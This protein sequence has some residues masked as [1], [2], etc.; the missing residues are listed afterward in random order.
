MYIMRRAIKLEPRP[1]KCYV[2]VY[3]QKSF[4]YLSI[5]LLRTKY[6]S[7]SGFFFE[8]DVMYKE[9]TGIPIDLEEIQESNKEGQV[10]ETNINL[11]SKPT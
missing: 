6:V 8:R 2:V 3:P 11:L 7:Q 1:E 10:F 4:V 5:M 9:A